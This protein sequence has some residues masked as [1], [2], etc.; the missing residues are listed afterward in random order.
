MTFG[1]LRIFRFSDIFVE[2]ENYIQ[3]VKTTWAVTAKDHQLEACDVLRLC[4]K[5][6]SPVDDVK[7]ADP[8]DHR[9]VVGLGF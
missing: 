8:V 1:K 7:L 9:S 5:S 3:L 6:C 2:I 4:G